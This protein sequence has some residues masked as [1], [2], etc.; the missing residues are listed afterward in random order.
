MH[1]YLNGNPSIKDCHWYNNIIMRRTFQR[2]TV[3]PASIIYIPR[4]YM[5]A[6]LIHVGSCCIIVR[7][8]GDTIIAENSADNVTY[9]CE[10][11]VPP[12]ADG[13]RVTL[14]WE[15]RGEQIWSELQENRYADIGVF[16]ERSGEKTLALVVTQRGRREL[17][18]QREPIAISCTSY[19]ASAFKITEASEELQIHQFGRRKTANII[20][21]SMH[22]GHYQLSIPYVCL[23]Q[24]LQGQW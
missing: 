3:A 1:Y 15:L 5:V 12:A 10:V 2:S 19:D 8:A 9:T 23:W 20:I 21:P 16:I 14:L 7:P 18:A 11:S 24:E 17:H 6:L 22:G 4:W 13:S